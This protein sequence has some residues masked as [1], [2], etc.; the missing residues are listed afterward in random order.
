MDTALSIAPQF[1][2][3][4]DGFREGGIIFYGAFAE[5]FN[6]TF[7]DDSEVAKGIRRLS[8]LMEPGIGYYEHSIT[9]IEILLVYGVHH[10]LVINTTIIT[11]RFYFHSD[12]NI[13]FI[14]ICTYLISFSK[15]N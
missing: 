3:R 2:N 15:V 13:S 4:G 12:S 1:K 10:P 7:S 5:I 14:Y 9:K 8:E 6:S 11:G